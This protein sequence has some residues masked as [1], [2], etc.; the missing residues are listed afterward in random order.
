[1]PPYN[2][3]DSIF[4]GFRVIKRDP[5]MMLALAG[6]LAVVTLAVTQVTWRPALAYSAAYQA[7]IPNAESPEA[8]ADLV[9]AAGLYI[10]NPAVLLGALA[11]VV[12]WLAAQGAILR[13]LVLDRREGWI[14]GIKLGG[15]ELRIFVVTLAIAA[16]L[17]GLT[18]A[19]MIAVG[20]VSGVLGFANEGLAV[21]IAF[22]GV[23]GCL[24]A[25]MLISVRLGAAQPASVGEGRFIVIGSWRI[26]QGRMW[27]LLGAYVILMFL[28]LVAQLVLFVA[29]A[30]LAPEAAAVIQ[31]FTTLD[32][33]DNPDAA[34]RT[35]GYIL[36]S[37]L[38]AVLD[39]GVMAAF[40][41]VGVYAYRWLGAAAGY[42]NAAP[43]ADDPLGAAA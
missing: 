1:M 15:D 22:L 38:R 14:M 43:P 32:A 13:G 12:A 18:F 42:P 2:A 4:F 25:L 37:L 40:S 36:L 33:L 16:M 35:P 26:T 21:L 30:A 10:S 11:T 29:S 23:V 17:F 7:Y 27:S 3:T 9:G 20:I 8:L 39:V 6:L 34:F 5:L 41:G 24:L 19:G 28:T 31:G